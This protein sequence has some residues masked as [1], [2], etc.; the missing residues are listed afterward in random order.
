MVRHFRVLLV[1]VIG[2]LIL[3][4]ESAQTAEQILFVQAKTTQLKKDPNNTSE[5]LTEVKRG[6]ELKVVATQGMWLQVESKAKV[7]WISKILT[8]PIKPVG[9]AELLNDTKVNSDAKT[10][11]R[12]SN[13]YAVSAAARGLTATERNRNS[14]NK[15]RSNRQAVADL[16]KVKLDDKEVDDFKKEGEEK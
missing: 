11:R 5:N 4:T 14:V 8:S 2:A 15:Q 13:E 12:R 6:D 10:S 9:Q 7:G 16:D 3:N 1:V